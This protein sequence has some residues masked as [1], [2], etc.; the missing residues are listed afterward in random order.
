M[1]SSS[2][3]WSISLLTAR[4]STFWPKLLDSLLCAA[5]PASRLPGNGHTRHK[6]TAVSIVWVRFATHIMQHEMMVCGTPIILAGRQ[7][8]TQP[9]IQIRDRQ[10]N[11]LRLQAKPPTPVSSAL[12]A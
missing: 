2:L 3:L 9:H 6:Q 11:L 5:I 7:S 10:P 4:P 8:L 1:K 12:C